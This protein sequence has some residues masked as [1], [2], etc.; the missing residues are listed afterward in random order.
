MGVG[1]GGVDALTCVHRL[2]VGDT[3]MPVAARA[4]GT[5]FRLRPWARDYPERLA[6][7]DVRTYGAV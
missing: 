2:T 4:C 3:V 5:G 1:V 7:V 6:L